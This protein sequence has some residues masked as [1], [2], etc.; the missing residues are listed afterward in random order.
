[1]SKVWII[2]FLVLVIAGI[3]GYYFLSLKPV[4]RE[5]TPVTSEERRPEKVGI[6]KG[7][8]VKYSVIEMV[9]PGETRLAD[10]I[11]VEITM[12]DGNKV[13]EFIT[14]HYQDGSTENE[15]RTI[16]ISKDADYVTSPNLNVG[17]SR[18]IAPPGGT[19]TVSNVL[20]K[21]YNGA[22]REVAYAEQT[23]E[24]R[25]F[26]SWYDRKTGFLLESKYELLTFGV[27]AHFIL[28]STNLW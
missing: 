8:W 21:N 26:Q 6:E 19:I 5:E 9:I 15:T 14:T 11:K 1:M 7:D 17:D 10:W 4:P 2:V 27:K 18:S 25:S 28:E 3:V 16:D 22:D 13:T 20:T 23:G 24:D 12:V